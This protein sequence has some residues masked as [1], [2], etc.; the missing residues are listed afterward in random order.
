MVG[1]LCFRC[2]LSDLQKKNF[3]QKFL[4][5]I[6]WI[7]LEVKCSVASILA[8]FFSIK[9]IVIW[10]IF[11]AATV[12]CMISKSLRWIHLAR[13]LVHFPSTLPKCFTI[14]M[15]NGLHETSTAR[16]VRENLDDEN[17][18]VVNKCGSRDHESKIESIY[19]DL[20]RYDTYIRVTM[21]SATG[22]DTIFKSQIAIIIAILNV[23][24]FND[25]L[26]SWR[27]NKN[28]S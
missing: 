11:F 21:R 17:E 13:F 3:R 15:I 2:L 10:A 26:R 28:G 7:S 1:K 5:Q 23:W 9:S 12:H 27:L 24:N 20:C 18:F 8:T 6:C 14:Y 25:M 16:M 4:S 19:A 22:I